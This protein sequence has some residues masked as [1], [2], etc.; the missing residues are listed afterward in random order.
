MVRLGRHR[1]GYRGASVLVVWLC[2]WCIGCTSHAERADHAMA[3]D[4]TERAMVYYER[5]IEDGSRDP[6]LYFRAAKAAQAQGAFAEAERYYSQSLR[7]GGGR[8]V[9]H[10]LADFYISTS[11]FSQAARVFQYL[12]RTEED[13]QPIYTNI[14]TSLMYAGKYLD[15][16]SYLLLAHQ[17]EPGEPVPYVNLGVLYD[18]HLR[19]RPRAVRFYECYVEMSEDA[20]QVRMVHTRLREMENEGFTDTSRVHLECGEEYRIHHHEGDDLEEIFGYADEEAIEEEESS[21]SP[22]EEIGRLVRQLP[23]SYGT[24]PAESSSRDD[25]SD[26]EEW[27]DGESEPIVERP[28]SDGAGEGQRV[29]P[30]EEADRAFEAGRFDDVVDI[31]EQRREGAELGLEDKRILGEAY[32]RVGRFEESSAELEGVIDERPQP[33]V[34]EKLFDVYDRAG[35][36]EKIDQLCERFGGWPDYEEVLSRCD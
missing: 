2:M 22:D 14:G 16:E 34:V 5:A 4:D 35:E 30:E 15:A 10:G 1:W 18:R 25:D 20:D 11:N 29:S 26:G 17:M 28:L 31:L 13:I 21:A 33:E 12:A 24:A 3:A 23:L 6:G 7:Y 36:A 27:Q 9:A 19:N 8:E 32:F